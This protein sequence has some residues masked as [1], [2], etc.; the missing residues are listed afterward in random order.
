MDLQVLVLNTLGFGM[1]VGCFY[2]IIHVVFLSKHLPPILLNGQRM[3]SRQLTDF[4]SFLSIVCVTVLQLLNN[5]LSYRFPLLIE[6]L[7]ITILL[8]EFFSFMLL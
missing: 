1:E 7:P 5:L 3:L 2:F 6:T 4:V 8:E